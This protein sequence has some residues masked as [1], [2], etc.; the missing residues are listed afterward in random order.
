MTIE[1]NCPACGKLLRTSDDKAGRTANCPG[2]G[3]AINVPGAAAIKPSEPEPSY[4]GE[5]EQ[6]T[7]A[8]GSAT[9][10]RPSSPGG[11]ASFSGEAMKAC[12]MCGEQIKAAAIRCR[13]CGED[14]G[15]ASTPMTAEGYLKP[16]RATLLLVFSI[17]SWGLSCFIFA[18]VAFAMASADLKE[19]Q[20][21]IMDPSGEGITKAAKIV[22]LIYLSLF[23]LAL[24]A[25]CLIGI[26]GALA[27]NF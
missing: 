12:P 1:F 26:F 8:A 2:C 6:A 10:N 11:A 25:A 15:G 17:L 23:G 19:M 4:F 27:Q 16:H 20:A 13:Y 7:A 14:I 9:F 24:V 3:G 21:G 18:I 22:S 5:L